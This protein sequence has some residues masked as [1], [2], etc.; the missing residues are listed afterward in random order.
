MRA[1]GRVNLIGE[2]TD[3][4]DGFVFPMALER[5]TVIAAAAVIAVML[6]T[7]EALESFAEGR[8]AFTQPDLRWGRCDI[9][10][11]ALVPNSMAN[12]RAKEAG[13]HEGIFIRDGAVTEVMIGPVTPELLEG[14]LLP[15]VRKLQG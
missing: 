9:K 14:T 1:P 13:A 15:L 2:H 8:A 3:Y 6:A 7:G 11:T 4:N 5:Y 12:Q 10:T